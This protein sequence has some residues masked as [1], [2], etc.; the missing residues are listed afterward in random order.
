MT[1][2]QVLA[3]GVTRRSLDGLVED[4]WLH[5]VHAGVYVVGHARLDRQATWLAA[6][7]ATEGVLS[8]RSAAELWELL[9]P[10]RGP[11]HVTRVRQGKRRRGLAVHEG[12]LRRDEITLRMG[13]RCTSLLRTMIDL[14]SVLR[15]H[16]LARA[17]DQAQVLHHLRPVLLAAALVLHP[18]RRGTASLAT[19]LADAVEPGE[20]D[21]HF[22]LR[23][24]KFCRRYSLPGPRTQV[25]F[26]IYR[27]DFLFEEFG[28]VVETDSQRWHSTAARRARDARK[29]A[30]LERCGLIVVRVS[31]HELRD[32]P[33][34]VHARILAAF[35][36][37]NLT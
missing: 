5:R 32:D 3:A 13:I 17:F 19:L 37:S 22:E 1:R 7:L 24:L 2:A 25:P 14:A 29:T 30:Y 23:F 16:E 20:I 36:R 6:T 4:G 27:A 31:W 35:E 8:H 21:S 18:G 28:V 26:G 11:V 9:P 10:I 34:G 15:P 12:S 33:D